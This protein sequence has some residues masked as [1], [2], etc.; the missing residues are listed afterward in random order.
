MKHSG[1][2]P[3]LTVFLSAKRVL[4]HVYFQWHRRLL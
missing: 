3:K 1:K 4:F 2:E